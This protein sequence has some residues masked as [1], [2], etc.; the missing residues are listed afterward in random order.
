MTNNKLKIWHIP[1]IPGEAFEKEVKDIQ[2]AIKLLDLLADYDLF[3]GELLIYSNVQ[4]LLVF[5]EDD[6]KWEEWADDYGD[7]IDEYRKANDK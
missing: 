2:E 6:Q 5:N 7:T 4:G 3:L 1:N